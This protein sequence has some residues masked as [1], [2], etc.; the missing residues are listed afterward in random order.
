MTSALRNSTLGVWLVL[1]VVS[2]GSGCSDD[3]PGRLTE[4]CPF[5]LPL[6]SGAYLFN[7]FELGVRNV[8]AILTCF[9]LASGCAFGISAC[10]SVIVM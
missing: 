3:V 2:G 7:F 10:A 8:N 6:P 4:G 1:F 9:W 5:P